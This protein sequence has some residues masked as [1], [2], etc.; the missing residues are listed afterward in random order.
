[1]TLV[2]GST[3]GLETTDSAGRA[4]FMLSAKEAGTL[5]VTIVFEGNSQLARNYTEFSIA[6]HGTEDNTIL[7]LGVLVA[8]AVIVTSVV[9]LYLRASRER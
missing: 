5:N 6:V 1:M 9:A 3:I 2:N 4:T 8:L 7:V